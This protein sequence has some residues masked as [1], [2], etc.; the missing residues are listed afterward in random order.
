MKKKKQQMLG[1]LEIAAFCDQL[2]MIVSAGIPIY[3]GIS[4]L[5]EDAPEEETAE[6]LSV[7]SN[8]LD[9]GS[10]FC[11][12]LRETNVFPKYVLDMLG[13]GELAGKLEEVLNAL[14]G[15]YKREESIQNSIKNAVTYP[16]LM[17]AMMLAVILV[18]IAKVLPVFHQ[19]YMELGSDVTG[20]AGAMM[21]FSDALN[22]YLFVIVIV[23]IAAAA[24]IFLISKS[25]AGQKFFKKRPLA[26]STAASRFANCMALALSS[27]LDTDQGFP[28]QEVPRPDCFRQGICRGG[29]NVRYFQ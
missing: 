8:S 22:Q 12:A 14:T 9:H 28:H 11:D 24:G 23:L 25:D 2:S 20:F 6:I 18:L 3:E 10:S 29:L 1:N 21:R 19:I 7:I 17:I 27:G 4:I 26:L 15:Y 13:I 5:Q 16:L